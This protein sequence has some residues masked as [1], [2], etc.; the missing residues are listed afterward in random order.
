MQRSC[1]ESGDI[2]FGITPPYDVL[3][4]ICE[5]KQK[6]KLLENYSVGEIIQ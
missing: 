4:S 6:K 5:H 2:F 1:N 3:N